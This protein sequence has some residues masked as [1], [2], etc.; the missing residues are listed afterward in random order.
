MR[1]K[2]SRAGQHSM[3]SLMPSFKTLSGPILLPWTAQSPWQRLHTYT[4]CAGANMVGAAAQLH[5]LRPHLL[6]GW[7]GSYCSQLSRCI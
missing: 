7:M 6:R 5:A 1:L 4:G 3:D 2:G